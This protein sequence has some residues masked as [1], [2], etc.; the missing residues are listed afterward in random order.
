MLQI[1]TDCSPPVFSCKMVLDC[2]QASWDC[3]DSL[4]GG[5]QVGQVNHSCCGW[6][7]EHLKGDRSFRRL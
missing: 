3:G 4:R 6:G 1:N 7:S 5:G 2:I